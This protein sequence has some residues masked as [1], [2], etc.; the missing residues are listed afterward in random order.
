MAQ[1]CGVEVLPPA[2]TAGMAALGAADIV[3]AVFVTLP[4]QT[5][6]AP[7][8]KSAPSVQTETI[9]PGLG[10]LRQNTG[11]QAATGSAQAGITR[12]F[13]AFTIL[14]ALAVFWLC[15]GHAL[16]Y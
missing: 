14:S 11:A 5:A 1:F 10:L 6:E 4:M 3:D 13:A 12:S 16:L 8:R 15:G 2:K 7:A 9:L